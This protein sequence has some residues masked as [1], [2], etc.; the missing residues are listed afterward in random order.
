M[1]GKEAGALELAV[2]YIEGR[3]SSTDEKVRAEY[4][5]ANMR[6]DRIDARNADNPGDINTGDDEGGT[7]SAALVKAFK[8]GTQGKKTGGE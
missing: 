5:T 8:A 7:D 1:L 2:K 6:K 4:T 3:Q